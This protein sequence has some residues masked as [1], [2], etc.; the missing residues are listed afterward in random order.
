M[1]GVFAMTSAFKLS[2]CLV[3]NLSLLCL[4]P[5]IVT[6]SLNDLENSHRFW[7]LFL[8]LCNVFEPYRKSKIT[9]EMNYDRIYQ[10]IGFSLHIQSRWH[11]S[12]VTALFLVYCGSHCV[13]WYMKSRT[14]NWS[15]L[16]WHA[17]LFE[18]SIIP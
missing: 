13:N 8:F 18:Y 1:I 10:L 4:L 3:G 15:R 2:N 5:F 9:I 17:V 7:L 12:N 11:C 16:Y 14:F 6:W